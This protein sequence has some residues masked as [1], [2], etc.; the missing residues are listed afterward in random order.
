MPQ[1]GQSKRYS[2]VILHAYQAAALLET[3]MHLTDAKA[4]E[5]SAMPHWN[6][7]LLSILLAVIVF[8]LLILPRLGPSEEPPLDTRHH[9]HDLPEWSSFSS[10][11]D[12][13]PDKR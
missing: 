2:L 11:S 3:D 13:R 4:V 9:P 1:P 8:L 12:N 5:R 7:D 6:A 10:S